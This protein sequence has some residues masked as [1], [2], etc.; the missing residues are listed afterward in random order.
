MANLSPQR[1]K[2]EIGQHYYTFVG[3]AP[4]TEMKATAKLLNQQLLQ[5]KRL[6]PT[7]NRREILVL[8]AFNALSNQLR[9]Q[10][11]VDHLKKDQN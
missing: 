8:L 7:A 11:Q 1:L 10:N 2:I 3:K 9:L 5:V 6:L 4:L